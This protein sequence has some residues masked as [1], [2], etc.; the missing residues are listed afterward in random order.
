MI[1]DDEHLLDRLHRAGS[2]VTS[3]I[4]AGELYYG[5]AKSEHVGDNWVAVSRFL[6]L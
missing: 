2:A 5:A 6:G 1:A 4:V 3:I